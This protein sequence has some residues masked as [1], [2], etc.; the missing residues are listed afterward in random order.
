[1][2][3]WT[4]I[5]FQHF[6]NLCSRVQAY[7]SRGRCTKMATEKPQN[8][9][10]HTRKVPVFVV[11]Q[12]VLMINLFGRLYDLKNGISFGSVID[13]LVGAALI[14]LFVFGRNSTLAVQ[15]RLIR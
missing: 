13:V 4:S 1:M 6:P 3:P 8:F 10:N 14:A 15:N 11:G 5:R 9:E 2:C 12:L 7:Q